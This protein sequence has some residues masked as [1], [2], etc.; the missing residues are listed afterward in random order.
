MTRSTRLAALGAAAT[1]WLGCGVAY[2]PFAAAA[3]P[4]VR[5]TEG[6]EQAP[7]LPLGDSV[8][9]LGSV[10]NK[11]A[12]TRHYRVERPDLASSVFF[13]AAMSVPDI[14]SDGVSITTEAGKYETCS[15]GS[16]N[17]TGSD[18]RAVVASGANAMETCPQQQQVTAQLERY[19]LDSM[20]STKKEAPVLLRVTRVPRVTNLE[21]LPTAL[22]KSSNKELPQ[23]TEGKVTPGATI[24]EPAPVQHGHSYRLDITTS[25]PQFFVVDV[26]WG[27][28]LAV[29]GQTTRTPEM[30]AVRDKYP[31]L[32]M[33][34]LGPTLNEVA[35]AEVSLS[36]ET[37]RRAAV[38]APVV[39]RSY[40]KSGKSSFMAGKHLIVVG[41]PEK[42]FGKPVS[43]SY[44]LTID[45]AGDI[46]G[47]PK[48][49]GEVEGGGAP[50][51]AATPVKRYAAVGLGIA[52]SLMLIASGVVW[53]RSRA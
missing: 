51:A 17:S 23:G 41:V 10:S 46:T 25:K 50:K 36:S 24:T 48:F 34:I 1:M 47:V 49:E 8:D 31:A 9:V 18:G 33:N 26:G 45:V 52:G 29:Q 27:Q 39:W 21:E 12:M 37:G 19:D 3:P 38:A 42:P 16:G 5:G 7:V 20:T 44:T 28:T 53:S 22:P 11:S 30:Q 35:E 2:A 43:F 15:T 32:Q 14:G 6:R 40:A 4:T 13:G